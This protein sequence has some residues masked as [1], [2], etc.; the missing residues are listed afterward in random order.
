MRKNIIPI[1]LTATINPGNYSFVG[2]VGLENREQDYFE[3]VD[4]YVNKGYSIVFI[5]NSNFI[6]Q[7]IINKNSSN[8]NFEYLTFASKDSHLG[9]G[10]GELEILNYAFEN[11]KFVKEAGAFIK[12]SGRFVISNV[13]EIVKALK[14]LNTYHYCN[15][16]RDLFWA[17]TRLMVLTKD[18][19][20]N[21][22]K[23]KC[24]LFLDENK[25]AFFEKV[26]ARAIHQWMAEGG[27]I[28][29][30]PEYPFYIGYNGV[31]NK[32]IHFN[33]FSRT[34]YSLYYGLKKFVFKQTV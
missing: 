26:Y 18:F 30:L 34:K 23:P 17:D 15:F 3:A 5:D 28:K 25:G 29:L 32:K 14:E 11:S 16:S 7:R 10:H 24:I 4:F 22:F 13:E 20:D 33:W 8:S 31:T 12:I 2:R 1:L 21:F 19:Y 27:R 9:K 6:S